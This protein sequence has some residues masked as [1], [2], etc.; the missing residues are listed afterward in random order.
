MLRIVYSETHLTLLAV[1][2]VVVVVVVV[3]LAGADSRQ[4]AVVVISC[5]IIY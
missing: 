4:C 3:A 1:V 2:V 5:K